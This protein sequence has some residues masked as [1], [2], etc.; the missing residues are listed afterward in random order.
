DNAGNVDP[1]PATANWTVQDPPDTTPPETSITSGPANSTTSTTAQFTF[2][3]TDAGG[4][5]GFECNLDGAGWSSCSSPK[6]YNRLSAGS[7]TSRL[8]A[9][10]NAGNIDATPATATWTVN[11]EGTAYTAPGSIPTGCSTDATSQIL[12]WIS[13][14]PDNSTVKFGAGACYRI[15]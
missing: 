13:Q 15:E 9:P 8:R 6:A 14:V 1:T 5:A 7:P 11:A 3:G 12:T 10:D 2:T 4:V